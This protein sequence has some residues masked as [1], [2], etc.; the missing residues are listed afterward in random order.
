[1][2][3]RRLEDGSKIKE[4]DQKNAELTGIEAREGKNNIPPVTLPFG[5]TFLMTGVLTSEN[6]RETGGTANITPVP[7][8]LCTKDFQAKTGVREGHFQI[9]SV[10]VFVPVPSGGLTKAIICWQIWLW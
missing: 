5:V 1:M 8:P 9:L 7:Q 3:R 4:G 2:V 10:F 6:G